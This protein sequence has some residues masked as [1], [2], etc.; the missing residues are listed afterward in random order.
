KT[1][2]E[3]AVRQLKDRQALYEDGEGVTRFGNHRFSVNTQVPDLTT[4]LREER[5]HLHLPGT[6]VYEPTESDVL[7]ATRDDRSSD[8]PSEHREVYRAEYLAYQMLQ[9]MRAVSREAT[10][11]ATSELA[12]TLA[13]TDGS[14]LSD[15]NLLAAVQKFMGPRYAE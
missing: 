11:S 1:I 5:L 10:P 14:R 15:D 6:D 4:V 8:G 3:D 13:L 7:A 2:R 9:A 12:S